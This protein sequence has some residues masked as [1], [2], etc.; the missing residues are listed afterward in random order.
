MNRIIFLPIEAY[1]QGNFS[2]QD[3]LKAIEN[4]LPYIA[5]LW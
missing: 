2:E 1:P 4:L 3:I 5:F